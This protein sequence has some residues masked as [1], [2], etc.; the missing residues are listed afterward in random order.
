MATPRPIKH[1]FTLVKLLCV[2]LVAGLVCAG[3]FVPYV[4]GIGFG[5]NKA[6]NKFLDTTCTL[7]ESALDQTTSVYA[8]DGKTLITTLFEDNRKSVKLATIPKTVQEAL[9]DTEDRRFYTH[10][11]VDVRGLARAALNSSGGASTL[12]QQLV[13]QIRE[14]TA[15]TKAEQAAATEQTANRKIY[16]AQ[17]ALDLEKRYTKSQILEKYFNIAYFGEQS[18][19][20]YVA[21]R[22]YFGKLPN[23]LTVPEAA[24]LT[25]LVKD[26]TLYDPFRNPKSA[27]ERR[28]EVIQNMVDVGHLTAAQGAAYKKSPIRLT[29]Q[30]SHLGGQGCSYARDESIKN[31]GFFCSYALD[32]LETVGGMTDGQVKRGGYKIITSIDPDLQNTAETSLFKQFPATLPSTIIQPA[33]NPQNGD[34][35]AM[36]TTKHY[37]YGLAHRGQTGYTTNPLFKGAF[38]GS[39]STFKYFS[40]IAALEAGIRPEQQL[41]TAGAAPQKYFPRNC[42]G[43]NPKKPS[44][45]IANAGN[46]PATMDLRDATVKSSNTYFVGVEDQLFGCDLSTIVDTAVN[47][48]MDSLKLPDQQSSEKLTLADAIKK[49]SRYTFTIGQENTS[50]LELAEAYGVAANDGIDCAAKPI[51]SVTSPSGAPVKFNQPGCVRKMDPWVARTAVDILEGDTQ[52]GTARKFFVPDFYDKLSKHDHIVAGKT[53]TNNAAYQSGPKRG[54]DNGSNSSLWFVGLTPKL[55]A[56]SAIVNIDHPTTTIDLPGNINTQSATETFGSFASK[57]WISSFKPALEKTSWQWEDPSQVPG[58]GGNVPPVQGML[59][60]AAQQRLREAGYRPVQ[61]PIDC[62]S[63]YPSGVVA[64]SGPPVAALGSSIT[65]CVSNGKSLKYAPVPSIV[66]DTTPN[67]TTPNNNGNG[68][69]NTNGNGGTGNGN[70]AGNNPGNGNGGNGNGNGNPRHTSHPAPTPTPIPT[71]NPAPTPIPTINP[72]PTPIPT[73]NPAPTPTTRP[74]PSGTGTGSGTGAV[75]GTPTHKKKRHN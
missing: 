12:T 55:V 38:S 15:T 26:P 40:M 64:Y 24:V 11:G 23:Q 65:Y 7:K 32:W 75:T 62:G 52:T 73:I 57:Y 68:A 42:P 47:L 43:A 70:G 41:T 28:D 49:Q 48:G 60:D 6:A 3:F 29:T 35:L 4:A 16:E 51:L 19:G 39:G 58:S 14:Y 34:I 1:A 10:H 46:Y 36:A 9:I 13:K 66:I 67:N 63:N 31:V 53:G 25:G 20:I 69:G 18:Y 17:C 30:E 33:V 44:S 54:E 56:T 2:V 22:T 59:P 61:Y 27:R 8:R 21:A 50:A 45:G 72:A 74:A 5:A 37:D 71:L